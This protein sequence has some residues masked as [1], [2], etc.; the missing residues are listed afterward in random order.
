[1][2]GNL[3]KR[4]CLGI[5]VAVMT[6][7]LCISAIFVNGLTFTAEAATDN[8]KGYSNGMTAEELYAATNTY[9]YN[10]ANSYN[11]DTME[12]RTYEYYNV[13][14][15]SRIAGISVS[16]KPQ[17]TVLTHGL[18]GDASHWSN[19][20]LDVEW[21]T[22]AEFKFAYSED[23]LISKIEKQLLGEGNVNVYWA[24]MN[25]LNSFNLPT[26]IPIR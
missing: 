20:S 7:L 5:V 11:T 23:S 25:N 4:L 21:T 8:F 17:I 16:D 10:G 1:M 24:K 9:A 12:Y 3:K 22:D 2:K 6:I 13:N 18:G 26:L 19:N 15:E 14:E